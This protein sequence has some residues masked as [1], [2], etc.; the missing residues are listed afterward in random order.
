MHFLFRNIRLLL[1]AFDLSEDNIT[2]SNYE[3]ELIRLNT[4]HS[5]EVLRLN[6]QTCDLQKF[7]SEVQTSQKINR[8]L[9]R[10]LCLLN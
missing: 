5:D 4:S 6:I 9:L 2:T 3:S 8:N 7:L 10:V 1:N